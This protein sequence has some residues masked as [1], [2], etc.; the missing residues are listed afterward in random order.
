MKKFHIIAI[1]ITLLAIAPASAAIDDEGYTPSLRHVND[2]VGI[3]LGG[4]KGID[5]NDPEVFPKVRNH[6]SEI[7]WQIFNEDGRQYN[8]LSVHYY[9]HLSSLATQSLCSY[10]YENGKVTV[11]LPSGEIESEFLL[12]DG[13][14]RGVSKSGDEL[15]YFRI[16]DVEG[17]KLDG[18]YYAGE[19]D[20]CLKYGRVVVYRFYP[21]GGFIDYSKKNPTKGV[22]E[23]KDHM[24]LTLYDYGAEILQTLT[25][26]GTKTDTDVLCFDFGDF[27]RMTDEQAV[28]FSKFES[29]VQCPEENQKMATDALLSGVENG[30]VR[31]VSNYIKAGADVNAKRDSGSTPL[32][33]AAYGNED[34][35]VFSALIKAGADVNARNDNGFTPLMMAAFRNNN[36]EVLNALIQAGADVNARSNEGWT[37]LMLAVNND[38]DL[39]DLNKFI[40]AGADI[41]AKDDKWR[42]ALNCAV[43]RRIV[44]PEFVSLLLASGAVVSEGDVKSAQANERLKDTAIIEELKKAVDTSAAKYIALY[45]NGT[46]QQIEAVIKA[47]ADVNARM[48]NHLT[49]LMAAAK[50]NKDPEVINLLIQAG[51]DV[52]A[53]NNDGWTASM[54]AIKYNKNPEILN[55]LIRAGADVNERDNKGWTLLMHAAHYNNDPIV[56][57][58]LIQGGADLNARMNNGW[59][60][61]MHAARYDKNPEVYN[62]LIKGG[63]D[64]NVKN[65]SGWTTL[66]VNVK[67]NKNPEVVSALIQAGANVNVKKNDGCT[68]LI[69]AALYNNAEVANAII[70]AG[71]DVN[72]K[73]EDGDTPLIFATQRNSAEVMNA[74]IQAGADVDVKNDMDRTALDYAVEKSEPEIVSLLLAAGATVSERNVKWAQSSSRLKD[75]PIVEELKQ[76][77]K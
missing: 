30:N 42:T 73:D 1:I 43:E 41:N 11:V 64:V 18:Y 22:Y 54:L 59:T 33:I 9:T 60:A 35:K 72:A 32:I 44:A 2:I 76:R 40:K 19:F 61:L 57:D 50:D 71:A 65:D 34:P 15:E 68:A 10:K 39:E 36:P 45:A 46:L 25:L 66:M 56:Y 75:T 63:A 70:Q 52:N 6:F 51:A 58:A 7:K 17:L 20:K 12:E 47:G 77:V 31:N 16:A 5:L 67:N 38:R 29:P 26:W 27:K 74:F 14:L 49:P 62:A 4:P 28:Q 24:L 37:A 55:V 53:K 69:I 13:V 48:N 3:W 23:V 21:D 8:K